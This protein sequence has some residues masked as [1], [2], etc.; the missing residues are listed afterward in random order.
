MAKHNANP[1]IKN[2][3]EIEGLIIGNRSSDWLNIKFAHTADF[4]VIGCVPMRGEKAVRALL[5]GEKHQGG[6]LVYKGKVGSGL[7]RS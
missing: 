2:I 3:N 6:R 7:T 5:L 1:N 4:E